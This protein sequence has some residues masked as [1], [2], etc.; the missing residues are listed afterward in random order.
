MSWVTDKSVIDLIMVSLNYTSVAVDEGNEAEPHAPHKH[1]Y[2]NLKKIGA[3]GLGL[4]S[5]AVA[6]THNVS[7]EC[8]YI[9]DQ[10]TTRDMNADSF[11][12]VMASLIELGGF[13]GEVENSFEDID[14]DHSKGRFV[15][16]YGFETC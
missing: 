4:T 14:E 15:F 11:D 5:N 1:F 6:F 12:T 3:D 7:I 16:S 13:H 9:N 8:F 2:Y 10:T